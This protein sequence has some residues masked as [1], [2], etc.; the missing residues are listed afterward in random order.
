MQGIAVDC[1]DHRFRTTQK[2]GADLY[3]AGPQSKRCSDTAAITRD[4]IRNS[5]LLINLARA[6]GRIVISYKA[7]APPAHR[8]SIRPR[9]DALSPWLGHVCA[10]YRGI[11]QEGNMRLG[12]LAIAAC[13]RRF[14]LIKT[15]VDS[16]CVAGGRVWNLSN[17][18]RRAARAR[19][20]R[21]VAPTRS[22][23]RSARSRAT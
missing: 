7:R 11:A 9:S 6:I 12:W 3:A 19:C 8:H 10:A 18:S 17:A 2:C 14:R 23:R 21:G 15:R 22:R 13:A 5:S 20:R 4:Y 1:R 16:F